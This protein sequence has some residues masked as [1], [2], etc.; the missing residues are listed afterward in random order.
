MYHMYHEDTFN[1]QHNS[2]KFTY[3]FDD[4]NLLFISFRYVPMADCSAK[5]LA[6]VSQKSDQSVDAGHFFL[7]KLRQSEIPKEKSTS[8]WCQV[9]SS[10]SLFYFVPQESHSQ[11][12]S[13]SVGSLALL[14]CL[15]MDLAPGQNILN[16]GKEVI[17]P[18]ALVIPLEETAL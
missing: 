12:G 2:I 9:D 18:S 10:Q 17:V 14:I 3:D 6:F 5:S 7:E 8:S 15:L 1:T 11:A 13:A 4:F 16:S